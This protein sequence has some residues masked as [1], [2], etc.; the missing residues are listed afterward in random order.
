MEHDK[1]QEIRD[2]D[3]NVIGYFVQADEY[4]ELRRQNEAFRERLMASLP[5]ATEEQ[6]EEFRQQLATG[7]WLDAEKVIAELVA[8]LRGTNGRA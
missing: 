2:A 7:T 1:A 3:G 5:H 8:E 6:E 4:A